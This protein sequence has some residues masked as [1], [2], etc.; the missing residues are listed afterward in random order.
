MSEEEKVYNSDTLL[1]LLPEHIRLKDKQGRR[2]HPEPGRFFLRK[3]RNKYINIGMA[4][5][6]I[7]GYYEGWGFDKP[8]CEARAF[9]LTECL[10]KLIVLLTSYG[11]QLKELTNDKKQ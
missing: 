10:Q 4:D 8:Q 11:V 9:T 3:R 1:G 7:C 2:L 5:E 6:Y